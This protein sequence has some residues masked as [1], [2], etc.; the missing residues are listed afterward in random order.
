MTGGWKPWGRLVW[1]WGPAVVL[2]FSMVAVFV[3]LTSGTLGREGQ[4]RERVDELQQS[5]DRLEK[6]QTDLEMDQTKVA[7]LD[8]DLRHLYDDVFGSRDDRLV[9]ILQ[10][11]EDATRGAGL[12]PASF[13]YSS[14]DDRRIG[15]VSFS[16]NFAVAGR[17]EQVRNM[18]GSLQSSSEFLIIDSV[19]FRGEQEATTRDIRIAVGV[20]TVLSSADTQTLRLLNGDSRTRP[21]KAGDASDE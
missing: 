4:L 5:I 17:Y 12:L 13:S 2:C 15:A 20:S 1:L 11:I 8:E 21:E 18:I 7:S 14:N 19:A 3:W 9:D 6:I 10:A 16:I